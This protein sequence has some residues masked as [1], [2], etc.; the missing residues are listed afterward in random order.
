[1]HRR[2]EEVDTVTALAHFEEHGGSGARDDK[3][4]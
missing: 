1:L 2:E 3:V 4:P